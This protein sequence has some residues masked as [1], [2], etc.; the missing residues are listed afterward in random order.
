[1]SNS[2][3]L[4][5]QQSLGGSSLDLAYRIQQTADGNYVVFGGTKSIDGDVTG[6]ITSD[7]DYWLVK[8][9][10]EG[11]ILWEKTIGGIGH[12]EG[13]SIELTYDGGFILSGFLIPKMAM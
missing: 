13:S 1:M 5:W 7:A 12:E 2:G 10:P 8:L 6:K 9:D 3:Q 4:E 11:N